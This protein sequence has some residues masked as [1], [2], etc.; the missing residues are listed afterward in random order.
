MKI[1]T[2]Y[3]PSHK[4][5]LD[6]YFLPSFP[7]DDRLELK[8]HE[9]PQLAGETPVFN[10]KEWSSFMHIKAK[11]LQDELLSTPENE[12]YGFLDVDIINVNN[13]HDF[14][15][16]TM[17]HFD[18]LCQNDSIYPTIPNLCTGV[19]FFRNTEACRNLLKAV[20]VYL[21]KFK[22]GQEALTFFA[23]NNRRFAELQNLRYQTFA[24]KNVYTYGSIGKG[25]WTGSEDFE[26]PDKKDLYWVHAN[27]CHHEK[28]EALLDKFKEKLEIL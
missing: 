8:I 10:S 19:I 11:I 1:V 16:N 24:F 5:M 13:F 27:Y 17:G 12:I 28:K 3:S 21:D 20:N 6:N 2:L 25:V 23:S 4:H 26:L 14:V 22:N 15:R 9:A 18:V 7:K